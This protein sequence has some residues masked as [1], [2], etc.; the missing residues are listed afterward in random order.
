[1]SWLEV[2]RE[3][4]A[5]RALHIVAVRLNAPGYGCPTRR[6]SIKVANF[7]LSIRWYTVGI[8]LVYRW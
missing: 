7:K 8:P 3:A 5:P 2:D 6:V 1:V 4:R